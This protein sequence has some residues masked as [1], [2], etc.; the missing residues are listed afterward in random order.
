MLLTAEFTNPRSAAS[1]IEALRA[2]GVEAEDL[3]VFSSEPVD[4]PA[5]AIEDRSHMS[6]VAVGG[7]ATIC[8]LAVAFVYYTQRDLPLVTGGMPVFS[9][10]ATGVIFYEFT[11]LGTIAAIFL[12]FLRESGLPTWGRG[13]PAPEAEPGRIYL[14]LDCE[15]EQLSA[16]AECLYK[17]GAAA[18]RKGAGS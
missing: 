8:L 5:S 6:L 3:E 11:L 17:E 18:V 14:R 16:W 7:A 9:L 15:P 12:M 2:K 4:L 1:A 13:E 10:W